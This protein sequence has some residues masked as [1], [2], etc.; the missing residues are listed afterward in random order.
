MSLAV[1]RGLTRKVS[2]VCVTGPTS[3][4][5]GLCVTYVTSLLFNLCFIY[6]VLDKILF[7]EK[8]KLALLNKI[9]IPWFLRALEGF[10][11]V[12]M[13]GEPGFQLNKRGLCKPICC[14]RKV[15]TC[16]F[17]WA[18]AWAWRSAL[19]WQGYREVPLKPCILQGKPIIFKSGEL[20]N[21][22]VAFCVLSH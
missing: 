17:S 13:I 1:L 8:K 21:K 11:F 14:E 10:V 19:R 3:D 12:L 16:P 18:T 5:Q 6:S 7:C 2:A 22:L 4:R 15:C 20:Q 9:N